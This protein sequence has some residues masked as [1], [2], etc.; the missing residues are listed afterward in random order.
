MKD[1]LKFEK[2]LLRIKIK[3]QQLLIHKLQD[4]FL[5]V[6][7]LLLLI[8]I[9]VFKHAAISLQAK[10]DAEKIQK[11]PIVLDEIPP[12]PLLTTVPNFF[13]S[14]NS[15]IVVDRDSQ[16]V[17]FTKNPDS[18]FPMASTTKIMTA[19]VAL[20]YYKDTD[21][22]T[23]KSTNVPPAVVGFKTGQQI[24]FKDMLYGMLLDSGNDAALAIAQNYPGG[25]G[26]FIAAMNKKSKSLYLNTTHFSDSSGLSELNVTTAIELARL[27][28]VAMKNPRFSAVV[29]TKQ[30]TISDISGSTT[31][32]LV[33]L[34]KLL[35]I[36]GV[37]GIKT[38]YTEEAGEVLVTSRV[39]NNHAIIVVI[40]KSK[41]RFGDTQTVLS[42]INK[43]ISYWF[44]QDTN[45][46]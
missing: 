42:F 19:L 6:L 34:N 14:A 24:Y 1:F 18:I 8:N 39:I 27:A 35:G 43:S 5:I 40:M 45:R 38:G 28:S 4:I 13:I 46:F 11:T 44:P 26:G 23:I 30:Y 32:Q 41:D 31:Y 21:V 36:D 29:G 33:N 12:Y 25:E 2:K 17:L 15:A 16:V 7:P 20:D 9:F 37:N 10:I 22:L 3:L